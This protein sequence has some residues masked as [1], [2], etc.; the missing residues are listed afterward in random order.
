MLSSRVTA[1]V[2]SLSVNEMVEAWVICDQPSGVF[3]VD[4]WR[5]IG[6]RCVPGR[7]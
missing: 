2:F 4:W 3:T 1:M 7:R 6:T 5:F